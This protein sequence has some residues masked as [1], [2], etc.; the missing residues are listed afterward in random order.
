VVL[1]AAYF[2]HIDPREE[3]PRSDPS[4]AEDPQ[5]DGATVREVLKKLDVQEKMA[6]QIDDL[7]SGLRENRPAADLESQILR[8]ARCLAVLEDGDRT[9]SGGE[10]EKTTRGTFRTATGRHLAE[11]VVGISRNQ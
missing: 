6:S 5:G 4:G 9:P 11:E 10:I 2:H 1:G 3:T 7:I 8:E